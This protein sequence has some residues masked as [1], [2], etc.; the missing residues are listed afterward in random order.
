MPKFDSREEYL[1]WKAR[2]M[3]EQPPQPGPSASPGTYYQ[4]PET[5]MEGNAVPGYFP[6]TAAAP[7]SPPAGGYSLP[8]PGNGAPASTG[9][10]NGGRKYT[11]PPRTEL[12]GISD[13]F[14]ASW[15]S[16]RARFGTL[17]GLYLLLV[18]I[19][20]LGGALMAAAF[21]FSGGASA[22]ATLE[23]VKSDPASLIPTLTATL[24]LPAL[25]VLALLIPLLGWVWASFTMAV[26]RKELTFGQAL[27]E[28]WHKLGSFCWLWTVQGLAVVGGFAFFLIPGIVLSISLSMATYS[29]AVDDQ[30]GMRALLH[31]RAMVR[32]HWWGVFGRLLFI[33]L[34][35]MVPGLVPKVGFLLS[36][37]TAPFFAFF[38]YHLFMDLREMKEEKAWA[39][40]T[41]GSGF[42]L[43]AAATLGAV[44]T[45][46]L[47]FV[48]LYFA[49]R[50]LQGGLRGMA[51]WGL[52]AGPSAEAPAA[53]PST[54]LFELFEGMEGGWRGPET[55]SGQEWAFRF[56]SDMTVRV[57]APDGA[58]YLGAAA[59]RSDLGEVEGKL[60]APPG[61]SVM[62]L[63]IRE[64]SQ[65][66]WVGKV[67]LGAVAREG[68]AARLVLGEPG[69]TIRSST[70]E[71]AEGMRSWKLARVAETEASAAPA[72]AV[73]PGQKVAPRE[74]LSDSNTVAMELGG[75][76]SVK[77]DGAKAAYPVSPSA[78]DIE[79]EDPRKAL[80]TWEAKGGAG[81]G[82]QLR[83]SLDATR[84]GQHLAPEEVAAESSFGTH[85]RVGEYTARGPLAV[86]TWVEQGGQVFTPQGTAVLKVTAPWTGK[87]GSTFA[88]ELLECTVAS[89][90]VT[91]RIAARFSVKVR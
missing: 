83:V 31:S 26:A 15:S 25:V 67:V 84:T 14:A 87:P 47:V 18:G 88:G 82:R 13:L 4:P 56:T 40:A 71:A 32:G 86:V 52:E 81:E 59:I 64:S 10:G 29:L 66:D 72:E 90:G 11:P 36:A 53:S 75:E 54:G 85:P 42:L 70:W 43:G 28:G 24:L 73:A 77:L 2:Q 60:P 21:I 69:G 17:L 89:G 80:L 78:F 3:G 55:A 39:E 19:A 79:V 23:A 37:L 1:A 7:S 62:D 33:S 46:L 50:A 44:L 41:S 9:N 6:P 5:G 48:P 63:T 58:W 68:E 27:A 76:A 35:S 16:Y 57:T 8:A 12:A 91:H 61:G 30:R 74:V 51:G 49:N 65:E 34:V 38:T 22:L 20:G 45:I